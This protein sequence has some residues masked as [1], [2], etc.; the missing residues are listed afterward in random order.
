QQVHR[1]AEET[2]TEW[3]DGGGRHGGVHQV[4]D[5]TGAGELRGELRQR[6]HEPDGVDALV[7]V[8]REDV[9][10]LR[11]RG[12]CD[13]GTAVQCGGRHTGGQVGG[14]RPEGREARLRP[15]GETSEY[16]G[17]DPGGELVSGEDE[18]DSLDLVE[19]DRFSLPADDPEDVFH[20]V[21]S[22]AGQ[23]Q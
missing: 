5:V 4:D 17:H 18:I 8:I 14:S 13:D 20:A 2:G 3:F 15:V 21:L 23:Q 1:E 12:Q 11:L 19:Q 22:E 10:R 7:G 16:V 6:A 9:V